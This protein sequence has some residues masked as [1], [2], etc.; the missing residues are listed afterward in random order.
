MGPPYTSTA[1]SNL[2]IFSLHCLLQLVLQFC[3]TVVVVRVIPLLII[4]QRCLSNFV[5]TSGLR[6]PIFS[7]NFCSLPT[8]PRMGRWHLDHFYF[9]PSIF[10]Y[11]PYC[12]VCRPRD[13]H[14]C[15][16]HAPGIVWL[17]SWPYYH[18]RVYSLGRYNKWRH[19][20]THHMLCGS[21]S[22]LVGIPQCFISESNFKLLDCCLFQ[23]PCVNS[24]VAC[25]TSGSYS[26]P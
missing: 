6:F 20:K 5:L 21:V 13:A 17:P 4:F 2:H 19:V 8:C 26:F 3:E 7:L 1:T 16:H 22:H 15:Q 18:L 9:V 23:C 25:A 10:W 24:T 11:I 12:W 14:G